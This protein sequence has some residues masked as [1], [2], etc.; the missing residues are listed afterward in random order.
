MAKRIDVPVGTVFGRLTVTGEAP[1]H[2]SP[3]R[4]FRAV[5][6]KCICG[7]E[8]SVKVAA[9]TAGKT[10]SC[11]CWQAENQGNLA[12]KHGKRESRLYS[13]WCNMKTRVDNNNTEV[14]EY[15]GGRGITL[16]AEWRDFEN[17]Y[18]WSMANGYED[19][20]TIERINNDGNYEPGNCRWATRLEQAANRRPWGSKNAC[21]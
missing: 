9:L 8:K 4:E 12:R 20:L 15:Y 18:Q 6:V 13:I 10:T 14:Y 21:L 11:G 16:C 3:S 2:V 5:F 19:D 1:N 17:F 7:T